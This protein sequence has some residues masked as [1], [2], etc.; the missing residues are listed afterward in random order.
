MERIETP[1]E[2]GRSLEGVMADN[3]PGEYP[4][5]AKIHAKWEEMLTARDAA[6][7][8]EGWISVE[9]QPPKDDEFVL[10]YNGF[11]RGVGKKTT[12]CD[13]SDFEWEDE[14]GEYI[15]PYPTH[16]MPLPPPPAICRKEVVG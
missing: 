14:T 4:Q 7:R 9:K 8:A 5:W 6:I 1:R 12:P 10:L 16:W 13:D 2:F 3:W 15:N 11:W